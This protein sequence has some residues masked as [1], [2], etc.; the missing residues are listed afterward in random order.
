MKLTI[1]EMTAQEIAAARAIY[2][3]CQDMLKEFAQRFGVAALQHPACNAW[4]CQIVDPTIETIARDMGM[5]AD[6]LRC[7]FGAAVARAI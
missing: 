1:N 5:S 6:R 3:S 4:V 2:A 7:A